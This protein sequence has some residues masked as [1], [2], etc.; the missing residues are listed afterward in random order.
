MYI[1]YINLIMIKYLDYFEMHYCIILSMWNVHEQWMYL[2]LTIFLNTTYINYI[3]FPSLSL[4]HLDWPTS[5]QL[6]SFIISLYPTKVS[7]Q[8]LKNPELYHKKLEECAWNSKIVMTRRT[9]EEKKATS[10]NGRVESG[11]V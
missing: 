3:L 6:K 9:Q 11:H 2:Y 8:V 7:P 1:F 10:R 5:V 4:N